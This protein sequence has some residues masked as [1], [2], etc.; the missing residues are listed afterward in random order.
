VALA[1]SLA[2]VW[3]ADD[4][5]GD[6]EER[7]EGWVSWGQRGGGIIAWLESSKSL[8]QVCSGSVQVATG[9]LWDA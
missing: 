2:V 1:V 9:P 5:V 7:Q 4:G 6:P 8:L 3:K